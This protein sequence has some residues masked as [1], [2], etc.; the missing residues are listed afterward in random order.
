M[1]SLIFAFFPEAAAYFAVAAVCVCVC[2]CVCM[3]D[4]VFKG[5]SIPQLSVLKHKS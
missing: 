5:Y 2:V 4:S 3:C 1:V